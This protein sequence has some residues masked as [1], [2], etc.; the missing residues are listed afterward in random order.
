MKKFYRRFNE[1][2]KE[3][4]YIVS[5]PSDKTVESQ[6]LNCKPDELAIVGIVPMTGE[7]VDADV[8]DISFAE[9]SYSKL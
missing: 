3:R 4:G 7:G 1:L 2:V 9:N 8:D 5:L 6:F